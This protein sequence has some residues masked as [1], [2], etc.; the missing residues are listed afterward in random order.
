MKTFMAKAETADRRWLLID[1]EGQTLGRL[2]T[3]IA[4]ILRGKHKAEYTPHVDT[5]DYVIVVNADKIV[6]TGNKEKQKLYR[7]HSGYPGGMKE[8]SYQDMMAKHPERI[9]ESAVRGMLPKNSLGRQMYRKLK[10]YSGPDHPH[11]AQ[12]PEQLEV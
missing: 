3:K 2:A 12:E 8:V 10:V 9:L 6:V 4:S 7:R 1:A 5:G 11:A